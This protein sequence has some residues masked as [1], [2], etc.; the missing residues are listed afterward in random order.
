[1]DHRSLNST[2]RIYCQVELE[3]Q[4][5]IAITQLQRSEGFAERYSGSIFKKNDQMSKV[6][7]RVVSHSSLD[8]GGLSN[9]ALRSTMLGET[10]WQPEGCTPG[11]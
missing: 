4:S 5:P 7:H 3:K 6:G 9:H 11:N 2:R 10:T 1:M 8:D